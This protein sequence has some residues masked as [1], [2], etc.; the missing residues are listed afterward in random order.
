MDRSD[1]SLANAAFAAVHTG[2]LVASEVFATKAQGMRRTHAV[3]RVA[4]DWA[5]RLI[6]LLLTAMPLQHAVAV[7]K[8]A[9]AK[10]AV[11]PIKGAAGA[12]NGTWDVTRDHPQIT[13][14]GG[15]QALEL[16]IRHPSN[17]NSPRVEWLADRGLC[18]SPTA[19]PCEWV[20]THGMASSARVVAGHLLVVMHI[21][22]D[23][24]DPMVV[25][26]ERPQEGRSRGGTLVSA[27]GD[28]IY[29]LDAD[30][31]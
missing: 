15:A 2:K 9:P 28:L 1:I 21:S 10:S 24:S 22:A 18:D 4:V 12:W 5:H 11:Q 16:R 3:Q 6:A 17:S 20:G 29:K 8:S 19:S 27:K 26:L 23:E 25:W 13:T 7:D 30:R 31:Q 14:K